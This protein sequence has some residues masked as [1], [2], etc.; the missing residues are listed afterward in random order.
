M[1][2]IDKGQKITIVKFSNILEINS[3]KVKLL[4]NKYK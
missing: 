4:Y 3:C 2:I 1:T